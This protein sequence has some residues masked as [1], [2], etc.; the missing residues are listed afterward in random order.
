MRSRGGIS[1]ANAMPREA[2][3]LPFTLWELQAMHFLAAGGAK[4]RLRMM[5]VLCYGKESSLWFVSSRF[6]SLSRMLLSSSFL[7]PLPVCLSTSTIRYFPTNHIL[8]YF[9]LDVSL[10]RYFHLIS[11]SLTLIQC[12]LPLIYHFSLNS[13]TKF[14]FSRSLL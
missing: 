6:L 4:Q 9:S 13:L 14:L 10:I 8:C 7:T 3:C 12:P 2:V 11:F 5:A 1:N